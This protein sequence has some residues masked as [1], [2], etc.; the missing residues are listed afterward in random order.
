ML[1]NALSRR[2]P[3]LLM[4][5]STLP[6][7]SSAVCTIAAPPSGVA[8]R[9]GVGDGLAAGRLDLV[10]DALGRTLVAAGAVDRAAEVVDHDQRAARRQQQR[11]LPAEAAAC[12]GDD[13][14]LAVEP[15]LCHGAGR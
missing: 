10:D 15:D 8:T 3:A 2:M 1:W 11:V 7:A 4:T 14:H 9:V 13:R 6:K 12:A 5:M